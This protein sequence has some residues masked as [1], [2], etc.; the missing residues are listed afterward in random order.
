MD[1]PLISLLREGDKKPSFVGRPQRAVVLGLTDP[2]LDPVRSIPLLVDIVIIVLQMGKLKFGDVTFLALGERRG[3]S[4]QA[5]SLDLTHISL[6]CAQA[7]THC[8]LL[9]VGTRSDTFF[10]PRAREGVQSMF[11]T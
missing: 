7:K 8:H 2:F 5:Q 1:V 9:K 6:T 10:H 4:E 11:V 3:S